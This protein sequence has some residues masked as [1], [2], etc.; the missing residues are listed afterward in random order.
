MIPQV[1]VV[2]PVYQ[3]QS[4][5]DRCLASIALQDGIT[6]PELEVVVVDNGS[7]PEI[8]LPEN[9]PFI[10]KLAVC[11][12]KGAYAARNAGV[13]VATGQMLFFL[14]A[15]CWPHSRWVASGLEALSQTHANGIV[16]GNVKYQESE[17]P[18]AIESYQILMGFGQE[19]SIRELSFAATANLIASRMVFEKV[20][21]F[22]ESLLSGGDREWS[23]RASS[24]GVPLYYSA[25]A[26]VYTAPRKTLKAA[27]VQARRVAGGRN[28]LA[29]DAELISPVGVSKIH[30]K[31]GIWHKL[32]AICSGSRFS[33]GRRCKIVGVAVIIKLVHDFE[34]MRI[35]MGAEPERR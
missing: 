22:N 3:D 14:D 16:G 29:S 11:K 10:V 4:G 24:L 23:W 25:K 32:N 15:D 21:P 8:V 20:G 13:E 34:R 35:K 6:M 33:L 19:R 12:K 27:L 31:R 17:H 9:L 2:I 7:D 28:A 5:L 18:S 30:A 26:T 1:S